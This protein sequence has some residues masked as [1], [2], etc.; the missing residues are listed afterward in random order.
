MSLKPK[1]EEQFKKYP[2]IRILFFFDKEREHEQDIDQMQLSGIQLIKAENRFFRLKYRLETEWADQKV[3]LYMPID[4]P[5]PQS[6]FI[7]LDLLVAN[8]ELRLDDVDSIMEE[9]GLKQMHRP[10]VSRFKNELKPG[11]YSSILAPILNEQHFT[12]ENLAKAFASHILGFKTIR[13]I[14]FLL[15][16]LFILCHTKPEE[17]IEKFFAQLRKLEAERFILDGIKNIFNRHESALSIANISNCVTRLKYNLITHKIPQISRTDT[18]AILKEPQ[19]TRINMQLALWVDWQNDKLLAEK[20][21]EVLQ[22]TAGQINELKIIEWYGPNADFWLYTPIMTAH[23]AETLLGQI[24]NSPEKAQKLFIQISESGKMGIGMKSFIANSLAFYSQFNNI[25][26]YTFNY[27]TEYFEKYTQTLYLLDYY[28]RKTTSYYKLLKK[29]TTADFSRYEAFYQNIEKNYETYLVRLNT[30]W[31]KLLQENEYNLFGSGVPKQTHFYA[32]DLKPI[33]AK[34]AVIISD[35]FRYETA[36]ELKNKLIEEHEFYSELS[37]RVSQIP[38]TTEFGMAALLPHNEIEFDG[39]RFKINGI[40]TSGTANREKILESLHPGAKAINFSVLDKMSQDEARELFKTNLVYVYHNT[41]DA[42]G[43]DRK[44]EDETFDAAEKALAELSYMIKKIQASYNVSNIIVTAD[45]GYIY[46]NRNL[47][48]NMFTPMP[49]SLQ[50]AETHTR[51]VFQNKKISEKG[52]HTFSLDK[53]TEVK[54]ELYVSI[55]AG[56]NRFRKQGSG[57]Q[58]IHGG[59]ALQEIIVPVLWCK[60]AQK[61]SEQKVALLLV[62]KQAKIVSNALKVSIQQVEPVSNQFKPISVV[63]ALYTQSNQLASNVKELTFNSPSLLATERT[64]QFI[65]NLG[66]SAGNESFYILKI[67]DTDDKQQVNPLI[68][69]RVDNQSLFGNDF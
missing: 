44:K 68:E 20:S 2:H 14:N 5:H 16:K 48:E 64:V 51:Y 55:P 61:Q 3:L 17:E 22:Y 7:L 50:N 12:K 40:D 23:I 26:T 52:I 9:H 24:E 56:I 32:K 47:G 31:L 33:D 27:L 36:Y 8:K 34:K 35:A 66:S 18:Y 53:T 4:H 30:E 39:N 54:S 60:K 62:N 13:E 42:T 21:F 57:Y 63:C 58:Y 1:I 49:E 67:Y 11:K 41:I 59:G 45:H 28:Y 46:Q 10:L 65:L 25:G 37:Y 29:Q 69:H 6:E 15:I 38:S 43:D 19:T